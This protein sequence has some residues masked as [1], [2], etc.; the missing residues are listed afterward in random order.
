DLSVSDKRREEVEFLLAKILEGPSEDSIVYKDT[1]STRDDKTKLFSWRVTAALD[2]SGDAVGVILTGKVIDE[3]NVDSEGVYSAIVNGGS[4][5]V[6]I[7]KDLKVVFAN[8]KIAEITGYDIEEAREIDLKKITPP[9]HYKKAASR[10][11]RR[12]KGEDLPQAM[13]MEIFHK[14]GHRIP[15]ELNNSRIEYDGGPAS[16]IYIR[17][18]SDRKKAEEDAK[19]NEE[20]YKFLYDNNH[21]INIVIGLDGTILDLN[22]AAARLLGYDA[23]EILGRHAL[24]FVSPSQRSSAFWNMVK[25]L[26]GDTV[27]SIE[28]EVVTKYGNSTL[29]FAEGKAVRFE[30]NGHQGIILSGIDITERKRSEESLLRSKEQYRLLADN[31]KDVI[32]SVDMELKINYI[33]PSSIE[34]FGIDPED[35]IGKSMMN[36]M[37]KESTESMM[38]GIKKNPDLLKTIM[39]ML[40]G[41]VSSTEIIKRSD[42]LSRPLEYEYYCPD[43]KKIYV[44]STMDLIINSEGEAVGICGIIRDITDLKRSE[45]GLKKALDNLRRSNQELEQL[46]Y[47]AS[48]DLQEPLRM[49]ASFVGMLSLRYKDKLD[50]EAIE[51][52]DFA[53][54]GVKRMRDMV[55]NLMAYSS[56][57]TKGSAFEP[58]DCDMILDRSLKNLV[59]SINESGA[60]ITSEKLPRLWGDS[61][62]LA[63]VFKTLIENAILDRILDECLE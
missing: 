50:S 13:E 20:I 7:M 19:K 14:D 1:L 57:V 5:G 47:I 46:T 16:A 45:E 40:S 37:P 10:F 36:L 52:I 42:L 41:L 27:P 49:V 6:I 11:I 8:Q 9:E 35:A 24:E 55:D 62:Q 39:G 38:M 17:D 58:V 15:I 25:I 29:L 44:S 22:P 43:G 61:A 23:K 32:W 30:K 63:S 60:V 4:D 31:L 28:L 56:V 26:R 18:I 3:N 51:F 54:D 53:I 33:S 21:A 34:M 59:L 48:H 12:M 2:D